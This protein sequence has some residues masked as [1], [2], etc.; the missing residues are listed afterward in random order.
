M[1][2]SSSHGALVVFGS[3]PGIGRHIASLFASRGFHDVVLLSRN[4]VRLEED[5]AEVKSAAPRAFVSTVAT[6][7]SNGESLTEALAQVDGKLREHG[8][9]VETVLFNAARVGESDVLTF[10]AEELE[11]DFKL[12]VSSLYTVAQW[13]MPR[14][15]NDMAKGR[16]KP[17]LLVT[18][19]FLHREPYPPLFSLSAVK[20]A[21]YNLVCTLHKMFRKSG[22]HCAMIL[23]GG[24]VSLEAERTNPKNI[25]ERAWELYEQSP[26]VREI[27]IVEPDWESRTKWDI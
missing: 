20:A 21:Q 16:Y 5:A 4:P 11:R 9:M 17:T 7:L 10:S 6:D 13:I 25:A 1:T 23:V 26:D 14:F 27:E 12:A 8:V 2:T 24:F 18:G 22:V 15:L 19:G 3:G